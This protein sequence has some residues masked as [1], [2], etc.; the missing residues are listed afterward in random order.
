MFQFFLLIFPAK[1]LSAATVY[2]SNKL[3][4]RAKEVSVSSPCDEKKDAIILRSVL[5]YLKTK[6]AVSSSE[7]FSDFADN[8]SASMMTKA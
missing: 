4:K 3:R 5:G 7:Y 1:T 2:R 8:C 6:F